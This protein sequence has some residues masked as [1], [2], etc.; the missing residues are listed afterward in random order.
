MINRICVALLAILVVY[1]YCETC[2]TND[3]CTSTTCGSGFHIICQHPD[4]GG[5]TPGGGLCTC[6]VDNL[7]CTTRDQCVAYDYDCIDDDHKHCYD[8]WCICTRW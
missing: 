4:D 5:V 2:T 7:N 8:G 1:V 3:D 6:A